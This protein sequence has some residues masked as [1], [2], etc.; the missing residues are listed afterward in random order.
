MRYTEE[1][2][3][4]VMLVVGVIILLLHIISLGH[5]QLYLHVYSLKDVLLSVCQ[6]TNFKWKTQCSIKKLFL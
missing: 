2:K 1:I 3:K 6:F 4:R 5:S